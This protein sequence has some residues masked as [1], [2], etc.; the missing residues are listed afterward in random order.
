MNK[1]TNFD[2]LA[3]SKRSLLYSK[4]KNLNSFTQASHSPKP[5]INKS[6]T[7]PRYQTLKSFNKSNHFKSEESLSGLKIEDL[8]KQIEKLNETISEYSKKIDILKSQNQELVTLLIK[9]IQS[10]LDY[11]KLAS[12]LKNKIVLEVKTCLVSKLEEFSV[13]GIEYKN[14]IEQISLWGNLVKVED[15]EK[16]LENQLHPLNPLCKVRTKHERL[17][18]VYD[19]HGEMVYFN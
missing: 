2:G 13:L 12:T 9:I 15:S 7:D 16:E 5:R 4:Q 10:F 3:S 19:F 1:I 6:P 14:E 17:T 11:S 8:T 18:A